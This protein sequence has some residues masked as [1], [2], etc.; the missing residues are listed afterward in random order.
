M[1]LALGYRP[2]A[3]R[4]RRVGGDERI[5]STM[6][7][8]SPDS[9]RRSHNLANSCAES[10]LARFPSARYPRSALD[11]KPLCQEPPLPWCRFETQLGLA[12]RRQ[13]ATPA[14]ASAAQPKQEGYHQR[15]RPDTLK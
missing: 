14:A 15:C 13:A 5:V 7:L 12:V 4:T 11:R 8:A 10:I 2:A 3:L 9:P 1:W 6:A